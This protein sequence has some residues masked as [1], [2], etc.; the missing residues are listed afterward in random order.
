ME[1][2]RRDD[3]HGLKRELKLADLVLMQVLLIVGLGWI[4]SVGVEGSTHVF[5]WLAG[6]VF[7]YIPLGLVVIKLSRAMPIEGGQYQWVKA[8]LGP[9]AGYMAAWNSSFYTIF[10]FGTGGPGWVNSF[11]YVLGPRANWMMTNTPLIVATSVVILL[12]AFLVNVRGLKLGKWLTGGGSVLTMAVAALLVY[13][14]AARWISGVPMAHAPFSLAVPAF[15]ILTLNVF[16]KVSIGALSGFESTSVFAGECRNP[17]RDLPRSVMISGPSIA[18]VYILGTG[19][20]LAYVPPDK[21]DLAAPLPQLM[22]AGFGNAGVGGALTAATVLVL[23][24]AGI[25]GTIA[26]VG[27]SARFPMVIAWDGFLPERFT[28]LHPRYRTPVLALAVVTGGCILVTLVSAWGAGG[29]EIVQV[30]TNA[31]ISALCIMYVLIFAV[32]LAGKVLPRA[33]AGPLLRLA[34]LSGGAVAAISLPFQLFPLTNVPGRGLFAIKVG[35]LILSV[36]ALGA[37]LYWRGTRLQRES[38]PPASPVVR[39]QP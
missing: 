39:K 30:G 1:T 26:M 24:L 10:N 21:I 9:F 27:M 20:L 6:I 7:L 4:G 14:L 8:G 31:S 2:A 25:A 3:A 35:V 18:A 37:W 5:L 12:T 11:A 19:A 16:S 15:S 28:R 17:D 23:L 38:R 33:S 22:R 29:Q 32:P 13:L 34:A 36:N